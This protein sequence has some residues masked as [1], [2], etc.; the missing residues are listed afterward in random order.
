MKGRL[1]L[2]A[3]RNLKLNT[4]AIGDGQNDDLMLAKADFGFK[5]IQEKDV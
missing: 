1:A 2:L 4:C 5:I 3:R